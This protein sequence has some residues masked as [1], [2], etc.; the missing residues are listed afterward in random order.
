MSQP[1][2]ALDAVMIQRCLPHRYPILM[3]DRVE[4]L[5]A[6][7][8]AVGVRSVSANDPFLQGHFPGHPVMPGVLIVE[9]MAQTA[10][11][12]VIQTLNLIDSGKLVYFMSIE[13]ARFRK[14]ILPGNTLFLSVQKERNR[15]PVWR[16]KGHAHVEGQLM[17]E[18]VFTAMI[19]DP[20]A[21]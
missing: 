3:I 13:E 1:G 10:G 21:A 2:E 18:A 20:P 14:P 7:V 12:L 16:F 9:A 6:D 11:V 15:G 17:A 4:Q 8:R 19:V 5:E